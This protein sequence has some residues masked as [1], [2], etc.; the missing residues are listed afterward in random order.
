MTGF[1]LRW[2]FWLKT[3]IQRKVAYAKQ[4]RQQGRQPVNELTTVN[5]QILRSLAGP[6]AHGSD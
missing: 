3:L 6:Q 1:L 5:W 4:K 2:N